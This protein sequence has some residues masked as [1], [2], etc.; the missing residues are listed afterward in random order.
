MQWFHLAGVHPSVWLPEQGSERERARDPSERRWKQPQQLPSSLSLSLSPSL[1]PSL[2]PSVQSKVFLLSLS[3]S[4]PRSLALT[5]ILPAASVSQSV[6][7]T[8]TRSRC[9]TSVPFEKAA[10]FPARCLR[11]FSA[12]SP[13]PSPPLRLPPSFLTQLLSVRKAK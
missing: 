4:F 8:H 13:L 3:P 12:P 10:A 9:R 1:S 6:T 2:Q 5:R 11:Q 7:R